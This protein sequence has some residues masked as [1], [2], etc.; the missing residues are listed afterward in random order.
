MNRII[1]DVLVDL[2]NR[3]AKG[4]MKVKVT[5][6]YPLEKARQAFLEAEQGIGAVV[7]KP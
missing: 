7:L 1:V 6:S 5:A 3:I 4:E 2:M